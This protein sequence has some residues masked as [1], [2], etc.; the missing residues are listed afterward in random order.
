MNNKKTFLV[1]LV[2][3]FALVFT[4]SACNGDAV[5]ISSLTLNKKE[6]TLEVGATFTIDVTL[7]KKLGEDETLTWS[8]SNEEVISIEMD[9][10]ATSCVITAL[11]VGTSTVTV[12]YSKDLEASATVT[13]VDSASGGGDSDVAVSAISVSPETVKL[14][15]EATQQLSA[16]FNPTGSTNKNITWTSDDTSVATVDAKGLVT[17]VAEGTATIT[18]TSNNGKT[19][20]CRVA[21]GLDLVTKAT[22][23]DLTSDGYTTESVKKV[24]YDNLTVVQDDSNVT[25][26]GKNLVRVTQAD[27]PL[28][29]YGNYTIPTE[30]ISSTEFALIS[31]MVGDE[32]HIWII[33]NATTEFTIEREDIEYTINV[34]GLN[35]E[36]EVTPA[37]L[38][39]ALDNASDGTVFILNPGEYGTIYLRQSESKSQSIDVSA[40]AGD[41]DVERYRK[42]KDISI[43]GTT[44]AKVDQIAVKAGLFLPGSGHSDD[45]SKHLSS[46]ITISNLTIKN[47]EFT[48]NKSVAVNL[49]SIWGHSSVNDLT[50]DG[51]T[52]TGQDA[53]KAAKTSF[54]LLADG[55][56]SAKI[57]DKKGAGDLI[58]TTGRNNLT[59]KNCTVDNV[60]MPI[61]VTE[62]HGI[63]ILDNNFTN[64]GRNDIIITGTSVGNVNIIDNTFSNAAER[65]IRL[66][67]ITGKISIT[68][69]TIENCAGR[70]IKAGDETTVGTSLMHISASGTGTTVI[71]SGNSWN[72][73]GDAAAVT[74]NDNKILLESDV[75]FTVN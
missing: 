61:N 62:W 44:G 24:N 75:D 51:C 31:W 1:L 27:F 10:T 66:N 22:E 3:V 57:K 32:P 58:M 64:T 42:F 53:D 63:D 71:L 41:G 73:L 15:V 8:S 26:T 21:V 54:L 72:G 43:I 40:W 2:L 55:D 39:A 6:V 33:G 45:D 9:E 12:S 37:T 5:T 25:I 69:N 36:V 49:Q 56:T 38:Q 65:S 30:G 68:G 20:T 47:V 28:K 18:A 70:D 16:T 48:G 23:S 4:L 29:G 7:D 17:A 67:T 60:W 46:Y 34:S 35:W 74:A 19:A 14:D 59:V 50:I 13:V 52:L 11:A